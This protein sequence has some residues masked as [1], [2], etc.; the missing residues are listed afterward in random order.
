M[1]PI[2]RR[3]ALTLVVAVA[4]AVALPGCRGGGGGVAA[5]GTAAPEVP[6]TSTIAGADASSSTSRRPSTTTGRATTSSS[7]SKGGG[8]TT[9]SSGGGKPRVVVPQQGEKVVAVFVATGASLD[10]PA[11]TQA[12]ARLKALGYPAYSGGDTGCSRGAKEALP[13]LGQ[14]SV[15]VEFAA[16]SDAD[17][18]AALYGP[19]VGIASVTVYCAD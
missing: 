7:S 3:P 18:F 8:T 15:S 5:S 16:R 19:V 10:E 11:F 14:Y 4:V 17:R 6:T 13:Q 1:P 2:P 9:T 12:I